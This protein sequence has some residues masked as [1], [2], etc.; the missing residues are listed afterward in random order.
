LA[1]ALAWAGRGVDVEVVDY[2]PETR[3]DESIVLASA[4]RTRNVVI[5]GAA[6]ELA[7]RLY[8]ALFADLEH[9]VVRLPDAN[10]DGALDEAIRA[11]A[12]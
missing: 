11:L 2:S 10:A 5:V 6:A 4:A 1:A 7:C 12:F 9:P 3:A 8:E